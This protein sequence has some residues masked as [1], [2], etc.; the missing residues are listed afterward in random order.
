MIN[1]NLFMCHLCVLPTVE[2]GYKMVGEDT[3]RSEVETQRTKPLLRGGGGGSDV[4]QPPVIVSAFNLQPGN[5]TP[6]RLVR[7]VCL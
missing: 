1:V 4:V 7:A 5:L 3:T 2:A 6:L